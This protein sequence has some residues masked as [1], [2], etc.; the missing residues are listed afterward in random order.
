MEN[1]EQEVK[2]TSLWQNYE[3]GKTYQSQTNLAIN[4]PIFV[5][6][7]EGRQ[8]PYDVKT[9]L[10]RP[11]LNV[12]KFI[13]RN[14]KASILSSPVSLMYQSEDGAEKTK[15][16][17]KFSDYMMK[18]MHMKDYDSEAIEDGVRKGTY[19]YHHYWDADA[20]GLKAKENGALKVELIDVLNF[21]VANPN[22]K[23][24]QKQKWIL[25][26]TR[27]EVDTIK[28]LAKANEINPDFVSRD[29]SD[30]R[31]HE[32]EQEG[33]DYVTVLTRY[34]RKK[35]EV[36]YEKGTKYLMLQEDIRLRPDV[37][38]V[39]SEKGED[40]AEDGL[41]DDPAKAKDNNLEEKFDLYP[42][43]VGNWDARDKSIYGIGEVE[44]N[45]ENQDIINKSYA[46]KIKALN[47]LAKG[48]YLVKPGALKDQKINNSPDQVLTDYFNGNGDGIKRMA[49]P[50]MPND[51]LKFIDSFFS[52]LRTITGASEV[53]SGEMMGSNMS[54]AAISALQSQA[55]K[56]LDEMRNRFLR[57]KEKQAQVLLRFYKHYYDQEEVVGKDNEH[58]VFNAKDIANKKYTCVAEAGNGVAYSGLTRLTV[59][60]EAMKAGQIT[61]RDFIELSDENYIGNKRELLEALDKREQ[62][63]IVQLSAQNQQMQQQLV[64]A[65]EVISSQTESVGQ[66]SQL[67]NEIKRLNELILKMATEYQLVIKQAQ[68][69]MQAMGI[70]NKRVKEDATLFAQEISK[71]QGVIKK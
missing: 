65:A 32:T 16:L 42:I 46:Y 39:L 64:Q 56:P 2:V 70:E 71:N 53:M 63:Q 35:G 19:I 58:I 45:I 43:I 12:V 44:T 6:Y 52:Y 38:K 50:S 48:K 59:F 47:D 18:E 21:F 8:W 10:P 1:A 68:E 11:V 69:T 7:Y 28:E 67:T 13:G 24:E 5:D 25:I 30:S 23:D 41:P 29:E 40:T 60:Q 14:K 55:E 36:Y 15:D 4:I 9:S 31:Y 62:S 33:T 17:N 66:A 49:I 26:A 37:K 57:F 27:E 3:N 54:G 61:F 22:E 20:V 34:Y 51:D